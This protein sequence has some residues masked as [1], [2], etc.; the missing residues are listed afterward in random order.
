MSTDHRRDEN[1]V[2]DV[3][4]LLPTPPRRDLP[5]SRTH[6]VK[7]LVL[8]EITPTRGTVHNDTP[9]RRHLRRTV[10]LPALGTVVAA[11]AVGVVVAVNHPTPAPVPVPPAAT[12][13]SPAVRLLARVAAVADKRPSPAVTDTSY[14]Y[15]DTMQAFTSS[16]AT[17]D[18]DG[19]PHEDPASTGL[20]KPRP[21]Q[22]WIP[23]ANLCEKSL[24]RQNGVD[25]DITDRGG[26]CPDHG[27]LNRPTYRL[28]ASLPTDPR[29]LLDRIYT[30]TKGHGSTPDQEAFVTIGD[31]LR[32]SAA[33]PQI[34]AALYRAAALIP[35]VTSVP[36]A[37]DAAGRRGVAVARDDGFVRTEW[38]FN[39]ATDELLG[40]R[41]VLTTDSP[42]RG[43]AGDVVGTTAIMT[44]AIVAG[45][46]QTS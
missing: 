33:P 9:R 10:L 28:L 1:I 21:R 43:R 46:G 16:S 40:E 44:K 2:T 17:V 7:E 29:A 4:R 12:A 6:A 34:T 26:S 38:I 20:D 37:T 14:V 42:S 18:K 19:N 35:G 41:D 45:I 31:M 3:A 23:V 5:A 39:A 36:D 24:L 15:V 13:D 32:E 22:V 25:M 30:E 8:S 11:A 27:S